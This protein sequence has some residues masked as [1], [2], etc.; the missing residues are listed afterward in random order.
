MPVD[1]SAAE[2]ALAF[3]TLLLVFVELAPLLAKLRN[4]QMLV[5]D[6]FAVVLVD[7]EKQKIDEFAD[8]RLAQQ[9]QIDEQKK[10]IDE[11]GIQIARQQA[12]I[13]QLEQR[14]KPRQRSS[15]RPKK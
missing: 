1:G 12:A 11:Q 3:L 14:T 7:L 5:P 9:V 8:M 13:A 4:R 15:A 10:L 6:R 2:T